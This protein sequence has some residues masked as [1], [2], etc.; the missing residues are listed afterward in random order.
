MLQV[1]IYRSAVNRAQKEA[2]DVL[3]SDTGWEKVAGDTA[4]GQGIV[5]KKDVT[6]W[7]TVFKL[8]VR[9]YMLHSLTSY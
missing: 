4:S 2:M 5:T 9:F 7:G 8:T 1:G 6:S 3:Y